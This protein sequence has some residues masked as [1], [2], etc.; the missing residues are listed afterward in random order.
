MNDEERKE[1][2]EKLR[3]IREQKKQKEQFDVEKA[4]SSII[5]LELYLEKEIQ[6]TIENENIKKV[7]EVIN[8]KE[9]EIKEEILQYPSS[10]IKIENEKEKLINKK[11]NKITDLITKFNQ[12]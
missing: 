10:G 9:T 7:E 4:L 8:K 6:K 12:K 5:D 3:L 11:I 2:L 1:K